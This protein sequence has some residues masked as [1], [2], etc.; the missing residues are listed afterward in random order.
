MGRH[1]HRERVVLVDAHRSLNALGELG[2]AGVAR[3]N[4]GHLH[5]RM[6]LL[7]ARGARR[8]VGAQLLAT[9]DA[10]DEGLPALPLASA[11]TTAPAALVS[12]TTWSWLH[13]LALLLLLLLHLRANQEPPGRKIPQMRLRR[14]ECVRDCI[15]YSYGWAA[16]RGAPRQG[17]AGAGAA[18]GAPPPRLHCSP[19]PRVCPIPPG[20]AS[21]PGP[22]R[23]C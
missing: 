23:A 12:I 9:A 1:L 19:S 7:V 2:L 5:H 14:H 22:K 17:A 10:L 4:H 11:A 15:P 20:Q 8:G 3:A 16:W 18:E 13:L 21:N 6:R